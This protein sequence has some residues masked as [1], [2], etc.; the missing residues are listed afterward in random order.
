MSTSEP[1]SKIINITL[2]G[3]ASGFFSKPIKELEDKGELVYI[4]ARL[5]PVAVNATF[6][7]FYLA[8]D[9]L[10]ALPSDN[11]VFMKTASIALVPSATAASIMKSLDP[12]AKYKLSKETNTYFGA[13]VTATGAFKIH[14]T[15][16]ALVP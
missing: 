9:K 2:E 7:T 11:Q 3:N 5:D 15:L 13:N 16:L 10:T 4:I 14:V 6:A 12:T 8:D 1:E